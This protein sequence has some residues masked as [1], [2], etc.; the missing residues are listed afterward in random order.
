M[1]V[2]VAAIE[3]AAVTFVLVQMTVAEALMATLV[4]SPCPA[5]T[6]VKGRLLV[7]TPAAATAHLLHL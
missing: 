5:V 7:M 2:A 3:L 1:I 4:A 6:T